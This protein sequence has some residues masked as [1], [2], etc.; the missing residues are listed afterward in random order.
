MFDLTYKTIEQPAEGIFKDKG[1]KFF[2]LAFPA[3][4]EQEIKV[5]LNRIKSE[6]PKANHHCYAMR[7]GMQKSLFRYNDDREPANTAGKPIFAVIQSN[8]LTNIFIVVVRYFGGTLLGVPGL[9]NA[10]R[11]AA[12][13]A[14]A[15]SIIIE[16]PITENYKITFGYEVM[17]DVMQAIK[18]N[19]VNI[20]SQQ[21]NEE[22]IIETEVQKKFADNF[23]SKLTGNHLLKD[24]IKLEVIS[25]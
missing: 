24:K 7:L 17:N 14:I 18:I 16:K 9:I 1:S 22:C 21:L 19:Q 6:H 13:A 20:L 23:I 10:Y 5:L 25:V 8:D 11:S 4:T 12:E 3:K 15:N 2:G